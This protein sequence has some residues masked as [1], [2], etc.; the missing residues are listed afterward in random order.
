MGDAVPGAD[1]STERMFGVFGDV[2]ERRKGE[3]AMRDLNAILAKQVAERIRERDL[4]ANI[5]ETIDVLIMVSDLDFNILAIN[6]ANANEFER[7]YGV[8]PK[9][10]DNMLDLL[11][12]QPEQRE[13]VRVGW[14]RALSREE[15]T[16]V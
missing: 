9:V 1:G 3:R 11:A 13:Q 5:V 16:F 8:R 15:S 6:Q 4:L 7:V 12:D 2:T 14:E 10:G